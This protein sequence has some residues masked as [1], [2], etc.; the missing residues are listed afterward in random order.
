MAIEDVNGVVEEGVK[1]E[2]EKAN[3]DKDQQ[4]EGQEPESEAEREARQ[5]REEETRKFRAMKRKLIPPF[6]ML[7]A[8]AVVSITL[9]IQHYDM[10]TMLII[11]L[12][13]LL[14]FYVIGCLIKYMMDKFEAQIEEAGMKEGEVIE[15]DISAAKAKA[16]AQNMKADEKEE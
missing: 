1:E 5:K 8:G 14:A 3:G 7:L 9:R 13:V 2:A 15:K 6:V 10:K 16:P 12:C 4:D 11:L